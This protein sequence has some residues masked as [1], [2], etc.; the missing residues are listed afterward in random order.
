MSAK[1]GRLL[2][3]KEQKQFSGGKDDSFKV[4]RLDELICP[5]KIMS[6]MHGTTT[7]INQNWIVYIKVKPK[8]VNF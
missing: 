6:F 8:I 3:T 5:C 2:L 4:I 1:G 7:T